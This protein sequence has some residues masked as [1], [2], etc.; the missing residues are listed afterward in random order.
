MPDD[1]QGPRKTRTKLWLA[2]AAVVVLI[3]L[4]VVPPYI[5][6]NNYKSRVS[7]SVAAA[8]GRPVRLSDVELR[9][10]PRP[11]FL[12][13][14]L[15]VQSDPAFGAEPLMHANTV[16]ASIRL[17]SLWQGKL[18][19]SRI[20]VDEASF[21]LVHMPDGRWNLESLFQNNG[22]PPGA[23]ASAQLPYMEATSSR[24]NIKDGVEKL[25]FSVVNADASMWHESN[26]EWR[27]RLKGQ[28]ARTDVTLDLEDTGI[29]R[30]EATLHPA[31]QLSQMPM[32]VDIEWNEAQLG[33]LSR[34]LLA[35][36]EGWR[37][38]LTG[39]LHLDGTQASAKVQSRLRASG[40][41]RAEFAPASPMDFDATCA[42]TLHYGNRSVEGLECNSPVGDGRARLTG[43]LPGNQ[44]PRLTLEMDRIPAQ[45]ALDL[46]RSMRNTIDPSLQAAGSVSGR[47][48]YD[49]AAATQP[50]APNPMRRI[51]SKPP[52]P[53]PIAGPFRGAFTV[54][55]L[56]L[57][58]DS[59]S[60]PVQIA[61]MTLQPAEEQ[62]GQPSALA[63]T[64]TI[65]AGGP[66]PLT[67][68][69]RLALS[70]FELG[71]RGT[72][73]FQ[74]LREFAHSIGSSAEPALRQLA[75]EPV[76]LDLAA[77]GPWVPPVDL[78]LA[79]IPASGPDIRSVHTSGTLTLRNASWKAPYLANTLLIPAATL[80]L[81]NGDMTWDPMQFSYGPVSGTATLHIAVSCHDPKGCPPQ[82]ALKF[83]ALDA[84]ALQAALL[85]AHEKGTLLSTLLA[86]LTPSSAPAWPTLSGTAT[87]DSLALGPFTLTNVTADLTVKSAGADAASFDAGLLGG[88]VHGTASMT[89]DD[90]PAYTVEAAF[91]GVNPQQAG[92]L[93]GMKCTGGVIDGNGKLEL[94]GFTDTDLGKSA[95]GTIHFDWRHG[96][97]SGTG[98][99]AALARFDRWSGDATAAGNSLTLKETEAQRSARTAPVSAVVTLGIPAKV[100]FDPN[101]KSPPSGAK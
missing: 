99:P 27:I 79:P 6:L 93:A 63:T 26:G 38:N 16:T 25:P 54:K 37:G 2:L 22:A 45:A 58:G 68:T 70:G 66:A 82:L 20:S 31:P 91:A 11:G 59:L 47:I 8:L 10:L 64:V 95:T 56:T 29:L 76:T 73:S 101:A 52:R 83:G 9:L 69:A 85:G 36:D 48:A 14:D 21:N 96:V 57:S 87:A 77:N 13:S 94:T 41:H 100:N 55:G 44:Q 30:L 18:Q 61:S 78:R 17:S 74:R 62:P 33:Q 49:P 65:P 35:S 71:A 92:L 53:Q 3:A 39:E 60:K 51:R 1:P 90:K 7:R 42:F 75:G 15:T 40:V 19:I 97:V 28:P 5:G 84:T 4:V 46:L 23:A 89:A 88:H 43:E 32:H 24:I 67:I 80:H 50:T 86:R 98:V 12:L 72:A 34:L 81:D